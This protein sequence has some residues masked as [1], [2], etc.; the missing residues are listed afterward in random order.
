M[1]GLLDGD[2]RRAGV[3]VMRT[4][5]VF[6]SW[7]NS[8]DVPRLETSQLDQVQTERLDLRQ[9]SVKR[10]LIQNTCQ[11]RVLTRQLGH[12]RLKGR[13]G[14]R[15]KM[16]GDPNRVQTRGLLHLNNGQDS[17]GESASPGSGERSVSWLPRHGGGVAAR[18]TPVER[19]DLDQAGVC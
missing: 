11:H 14:G 12:H 16:A 13:Q 17:R 10:G 2:R 19:T 4:I 3:R 1:C 6:K 8:L 5:K 18:P 15:A 9:H 7:S